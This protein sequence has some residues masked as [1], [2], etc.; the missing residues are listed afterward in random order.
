M[1]APRITVSGAGGMTHHAH[2]HS[3]PHRVVR[4]VE[5]AIRG[6]EVP[7]KAHPEWFE[8]Y[9]FVVRR[10]PPPS[11][12]TEPATSESG[13]VTLLEHVKPDDAGVGNKGL[14]SLPHPHRA[15]FFTHFHWVDAEGAPQT[16]STGKEG[17][18]TM[19]LRADRRF[20]QVT[21]EE[22]INTFD[23]VV[24][25][26]EQAF[27]AYLDAHLVLL[28]PRAQKLNHIPA[29]KRVY[30]IAVDLR[31]RVS[32]LHELAGEYSSAAA[33]WACVGL[34]DPRGGG[35]GSEVSP[36]SRG[37]TCIHHSGLWRVPVV[38]VGCR[39]DGRHPT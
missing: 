29:Y 16:V 21:R 18:E 23:A 27:A 37:L 13:T 5:T 38:P 19:R 3:T 7:W 11:S 28:Q 12:S 22:L 35:H 25:A 2:G 34:T 1:V 6:D 4:F 39:D 31:R 10:P 30:D 36:R 26:F 32:L 9:D 17:D 8:R 33:T 20:V 14:N 24:E 15:M